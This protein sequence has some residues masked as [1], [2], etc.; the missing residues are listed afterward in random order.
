MI[1]KHLW[2]L[3]LWLGA[4]DLA[5]YLFFFSLGDAESINELAKIYADKATPYAVPGV[6][7]PLPI[8][9]IP[10]GLLNLDPAAQK[11]AG[12]ILCSQTI[13]FSKYSCDLARSIVC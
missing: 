11:A 12:D 5:I 4:P 13:Q 6:A 9:A 1:G 7:A 2:S 3:K 8:P 10:A